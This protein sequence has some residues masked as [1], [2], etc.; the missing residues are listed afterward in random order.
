MFTLV[1]SKDAGVENLTLKQVRD[2]FAGRVRKWSDIGGN[3]VPV[4]LI[5][6]DPGSGTRSTL[7]DKV[8]DGKEP[9]QFTV[10]DCAALDPDRYG[11]CEVTS[12]DTLLNRTA[13]TPGAIG[14]SEAAGVDGHK[15]AGNLVKLR[16]D[17]REPTAQGVEDTNYPYWQT[18]YAYTYGSAPA[19]SVAAAFLNFLTQQS[20]RDILHAHGHG[21][22]S[23]AE[24]SGE[25]RPI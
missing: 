3:P 17:G 2:L 4:H 13:S 5:N 19:G 24:N 9:P 11:T 16:I 14:Y 1:V 22:C 18:E 12:T 7:V 6:R 21:L 25:C 8:L 23:E 10:R 15:A 20:G